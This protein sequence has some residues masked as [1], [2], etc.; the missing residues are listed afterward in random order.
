MRMDQKVYEN[1][2]RN[3]KIVWCEREQ[4]NWVGVQLVCLRKGISNFLIYFLFD[5]IRGNKELIDFKLSDST[6]KTWVK[7]LELRK[8]I[9]NIGTIQSRQKNSSQNWWKE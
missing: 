9:K 2:G 7:M 5:F 1:W 6:E 4:R 3:L 8:I